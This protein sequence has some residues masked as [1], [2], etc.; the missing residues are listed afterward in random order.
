M[1]EGNKHNMED[2]DRMTAHARWVTI[3]T[4]HGC[5]SVA[6]ISNPII[7][8]SKKA[9]PAYLITRGTTL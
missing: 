2:E 4:G 1:S 8:Y 9:S 3:A 6:G 5:D 7:L